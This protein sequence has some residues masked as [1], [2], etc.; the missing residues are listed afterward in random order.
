[1]LHTGVR[2]KPCS[3]LQLHNTWWWSSM[4]SIFPCM[5]KQEFSVNFGQ[6]WQLSLHYKIP[7]DLEVAEPAELLFERPTILQSSSLPWSWQNLSSLCR[8]YKCC[9][10]P[11]NSLLWASCILQRKVR[12]WGLCCCNSL[13]KCSSWMGVPWLMDT[14]NTTILSGML[15]E[16]RLEA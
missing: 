12:L 10:S 1:M 7:S 6:I 4:V 8:L 11:A 16:L 9:H 14:D 2:G 3:A 5:Q 13:S 15:Q